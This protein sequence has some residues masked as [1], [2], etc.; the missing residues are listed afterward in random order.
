MAKFE[1]DIDID[2]PVATVW[3][4]V[5][6]SQQWPQWFPDMDTI[7]DIGT[8]EAGETFTWE[9][10]GKEATGK[11][12]RAEDQSRMQL[13]TNADGHRHTHTFSLHHRGG[14]FGIGGEK[15]RLEY[16]LEYE[17]TG[18]VIGEFIARGNPIDM[19]KVRNV[20][21]EI[22]ALAEEAPR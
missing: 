14:V 6:T 8:A 10:D 4:I 5:N 18:G 1:N 19:I 15:S 7:Q 17:A 20:L 3:A 21:K 2:A 16:S 13:V 22:K 9:R 11:V 12:V